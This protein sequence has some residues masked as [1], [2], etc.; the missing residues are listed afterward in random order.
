MASSIATM[1]TPSRPDRL[2]GRVRGEQ[3]TSSVP[4]MTNA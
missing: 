1:T 4:A 2:L 3:R